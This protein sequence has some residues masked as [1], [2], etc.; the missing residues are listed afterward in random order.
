MV[1][2]E[3]SGHREPALRPGAGHQFAA[4]ALHPLPH[5]Q[6]PVARAE[7]RGWSVVDDAHMQLVVPGPHLDAHRHRPDHED[8][9][10]A[11]AQRG[12]RRQGTFTAR[13]VTLDTDTD[14]GTTHLRAGS[15][16]SGRV[17]LTHTANDGTAGACH[18]VSSLGLRVHGV[19][20]TGERAAQQSLAHHAGTAR[21]DDLE[22]VIRRAFARSTCR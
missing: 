17:V 19:S 20:D 14:T 11:E 10:H 18:A 7:L 3:P 22:P 15:T 8:L 4:H 9:D 13:P 12:E 1:Q 16:W 6:Q 5:A 2:R 21:P